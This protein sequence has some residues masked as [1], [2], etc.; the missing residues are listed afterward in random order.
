VS[1]DAAAAAGA[2][3]GP[4][5]APLM[6]PAIAHRLRE[7]GKLQMLHDATALGLGNMMLTV[8]LVVGFEDRF[9][10]WLA[11]ENGVRYMYQDRPLPGSMTWE[12]YKADY[13]A[14][15]GAPEK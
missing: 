3:L 15:C 11:A 4:E 14:V 12:G 13:A 8:G 7:D 5:L 9:L 1:G 10:V 2:R 6:D